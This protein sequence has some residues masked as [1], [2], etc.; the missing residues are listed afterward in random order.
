[1]Q[2]YHKSN[3]NRA[4]LLHASFHVDCRTPAHTMNE[5]LLTRN[6]L[7]RPLHLREHVATPPTVQDDLPVLAARHQ[8]RQ[9]PGQI[10]HNGLNGGCFPWFLQDSSHCGRCSTRVPRIQ[11]QSQAISTQLPV[12]G[13]TGAPLRFLNVRL[14]EGRIDLHRAEMLMPEHALKL[15]HAAAVA[16]EVDGEGMAE[17]VD[18][19]ARDK[20]PRPRSLRTGFLFLW[21]LGEDSNFQ[22]SD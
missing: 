21:L 6:Q 2:F 22:H 18:C 11:D 10:N 7:A 16:Q 13:R 3:G 12:V 8:L 14:G 9:L 17:L 1:M 15:Q 19:G 4:P 20:K 5:T